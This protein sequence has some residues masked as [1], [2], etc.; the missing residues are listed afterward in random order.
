MGIGKGNQTAPDSPPREPVDIPPPR[1]PSSQPD[2]KPLDDPSLLPDPKPFDDP[3]P[4]KP[5]KT[6]L[7]LPI[8]TE[9]ERLIAL[10]DLDAAQLDRLSD[11]R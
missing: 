8:D 10:L 11:V 1:D 4:T 3:R 9:I 7:A 2:P 6:M 5:R